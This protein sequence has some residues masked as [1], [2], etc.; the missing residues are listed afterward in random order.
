MR[1]YTCANVIQSASLAYYSERFVEDFTPTVVIVTE[2]LEHAVPLK[3]YQVLVTYPRVENDGIRSYRDS[4]SDNSRFAAYHHVICTRGVASIEQNRPPTPKSY[5][6]LTHH[7]I[8]C[9][10]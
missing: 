7:Q 5:V 3:S 6:T 1:S 10:A 9:T 4:I 8:H 2:T